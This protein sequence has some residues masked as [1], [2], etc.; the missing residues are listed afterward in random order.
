MSFHSIK[1]DDHFYD[2]SKKHAVAEHRTISGQV[3]YWAKIGKL[4]LENPDIPVT[5][6]KDIL[7]AKELKTEAEVFEFR[8]E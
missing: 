2:I 3:S 4:S 7:L 5:M 8:D 6:L 1:I